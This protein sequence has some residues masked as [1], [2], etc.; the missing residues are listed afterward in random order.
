[1]PSRST[2]YSCRPILK[3]HSCSPSVCAASRVAHS[4]GPYVAQR[5]PS[6]HCHTARRPTV[7][8]VGAR[9]A[10]TSVGSGGSSACTKSIVW[11]S[12]VADSCSWVPPLADWFRDMFRETEA[13]PEADLS[14]GAADCPTSSGVIS[15]PTICSCSPSARIGHARSTAAIIPS[16]SETVDLPTTCGDDETSARSFETRLCSVSIITWSG[17]A[18][19]RWISLAKQV[20]ADSTSA[21]SSRSSRLDN[22]GTTSL[23]S[24]NCAGDTC[25]HSL[26][27]VATAER[28]SAIGKKSM[29]ERAELSPP[30][31][32]RALPW[33]TASFPIVSRARSARSMY[34]IDMSLAQ[35]DGAHCATVDDDCG[36]ASTML[37]SASHA[38]SATCGRWSACSSWCSTGTK[39][40]GRNPASVSSLPISKMSAS[41]RSAVS[42]RKSSSSADRSSRSW[43]YRDPPPPREKRDPP[44][45][46]APKGLPPPNSTPG[47]PP[48][49]TRASSCCSAEAGSTPPSSAPGAGAPSAAAR[50]A[51]ISA[52]ASPGSSG[53]S[54]SP[55]MAGAAL[56]FRTRFGDLLLF[57]PRFGAACGLPRG[58]AAVESPSPSACS[59]RSRFDRRR[60]TRELSFLGA[61]PLRRELRSGAAAAA[62]AGRPEAESAFATSLSLRDR[63]LCDSSTAALPSSAAAAACVT[64]FLFG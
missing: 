24:W 53:D 23:H 39:L 37:C 40:S 62:A 59:A 5:S 1:M 2:A 52:S 3:K 50:A 44:P 63:R 41:L 46:K 30:A 58:G 29:K 48:L 60:E 6:R 31:L 35:S 21:L 11:P 54:S 12:C 45:A 13:S 9:C 10:R 56:A 14:A 36:I 15:S 4:S 28:C 55:D 19:H 27:A 47:C 51:A 25:A 20:Q 43:L 18:S 33:S 8:I 22:C 34:S 32:R 26:A 17:D 64:R 57:P 49:A 61:L 16:A 38:S 42:C 7:A